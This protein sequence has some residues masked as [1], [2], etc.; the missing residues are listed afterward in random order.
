MKFFSVSNNSVYKMGFP[1]IQTIS[2]GA[3]DLPP[4]QVCGG[5][6]TNIAGDITISLTPGKGTKWPDLMGIGHYPLF[7]VSERVLDAWR[8]EHVGKY[9][10]HR[11]EILP[12]L[13]KTMKDLSPPAYFWIDGGKMRGALVDFKAS[14]F[15]GVKFCPACNR[16]LENTSATYDRQHS[17]TWPYAFVPGSWKGENLFTTD[18]SDTRFFCTDVVLECARKYKLTNFRFI[19]I[20]EGNGSG[21]KGVEYLR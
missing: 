20:E 19:P 1:W 16:R 6:G 21:S 11:V 18:I 14:G 3:E 8:R 4:C 9:P 5:L 15:V 10:H 12:P 17:K 7:I 2:S 13:P